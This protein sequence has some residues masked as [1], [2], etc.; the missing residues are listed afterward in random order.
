MTA[1]LLLDPAGGD[2]SLL[3]GP[4]L[5]HGWLGSWGETKSPEEESP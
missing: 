4:D 2:W 1:A 3:A 5:E